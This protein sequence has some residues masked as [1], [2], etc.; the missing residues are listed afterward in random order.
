MTPTIEDVQCA[1]VAY[2]PDLEP[3]WI[4]SPARPRR[5]AWPRQVAMT[6]ARRIT[7]KSYP[8]IGIKFRRDHTTAIWS[9]R[10]TEARMAPYPEIAAAVTAITA[11]AMRRAEARA[12]RTER[13]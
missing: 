2:Y 1:A 13:E 8:Q 3:G 9:V 12:N 11:L 5:I 4:N 7:G 6:V 10:A